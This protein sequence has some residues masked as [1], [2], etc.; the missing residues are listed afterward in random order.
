MSEIKIINLPD[1]ELE[2]NI[3][4]YSAANFQSSIENDIENEEID[5]VDDSAD[6]G[7]F[8]D[9]AEEFVGTVIDRVIDFS[10]QWLA[11]VKNLL[12]SD[13]IDVSF[14][15][16]VRIGEIASRVFPVVSAVIPPL[17]ETF[18]YTTIEGEGLEGI[19]N[20][21]YEITGAAIGGVATGAVMAA[22]FASNPAGWVVA[23]ALGLCVIGSI[24]I[25]NLG[26]YYDSNDAVPADYM[27]NV[28]FY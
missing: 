5:L 24:A 11:N 7:V 16:A 25:E 17:W 12:Y 26:A 10:A 18:K 6:L 9:V 15:Q 13:I 3:S 23:G 20:H 19:V 8:N 14:G 1:L 21:K 27:S 22:I 28:Y 2:N 4:T